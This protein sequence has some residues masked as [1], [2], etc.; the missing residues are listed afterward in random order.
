MEFLIFRLPNE[1]KIRYV[2]NQEAVNSTASFFPFDKGEI[3]HIFFDHSIKN[4]S[5]LLNLPVLL[6]GLL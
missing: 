2:K 3:F 1:K 6:S 4:F 5:F